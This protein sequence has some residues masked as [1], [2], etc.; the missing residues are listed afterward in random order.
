MIKKPSRKDT[1]AHFISDQVLTSWYGSRIQYQEKL[2]RL[3]VEGDSFY[4]KNHSKCLVMVFL[5]LVHW[6]DKVVS[7]VISELYQ[8]FFDGQKLM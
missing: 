5:F 4:F 1:S 6:Q 8:S 3:V 2:E 7:S